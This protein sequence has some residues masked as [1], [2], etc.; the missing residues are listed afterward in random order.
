MTLDDALPFRLA[1][2]EQV[3]VLLGCVIGLLAQGIIRIYE[4]SSIQQ[5]LTLPFALAAINQVSFSA[6]IIEIA[7][8]LASFLTTIGLCVLYYRVLSSAHPLHHVPGPILAR[9]TQLGQF[10][11][12]VI[13]KPRVY[14]RRL[15][16]LFGPIVRIGP[17]EV[18]ICDASV[19]T[20]VFGAKPWLKGKAYSFTASGGAAASETALSAIRDRESSIWVF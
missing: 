8:V 10:Y 2:I 15:H 6:T 18:S 9:I 17:N 7:L 20:T 19:L 1:T 11:Q 14:Q 16:Q 13:G 3:C 4:P 12:L 5:Y